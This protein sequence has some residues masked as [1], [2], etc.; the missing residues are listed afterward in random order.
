[1]L[2]L[3]DYSKGQ[4]EYQANLA[5]FGD[6]VLDTMHARTYEKRERVVKEKPPQLQKCPACGIV[7]VLVLEHYATT[8]IDCHGMTDELVRNPRW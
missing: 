8:C 7:S 1:M 4:G 5:A 6:P 3:I 2:K